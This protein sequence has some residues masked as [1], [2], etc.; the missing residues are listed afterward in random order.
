MLEFKKVPVIIWVS[1]YS[2]SLTFFSICN[3]QVCTTS[4]FVGYFLKD[5]GWEKGHLATDLLPLSSDVITCWEIRPGSRS[6]L[7]QSCWMGW[8]SCLR[9]VKVFNTKVRKPFFTVALLKQERAFPDKTIKN[10]LIVHLLMA[11]KSKS[12]VRNQTESVWSQW[13]RQ[14]MLFLNIIFNIFLKKDVLLHNLNRMN[15]LTSMPHQH[16]N[17]LFSVN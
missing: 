1:V 8:R 11:L 4:P 15:L 10:N 12:W 9:Q 2:Q 17:R 6:S 13:Q 5:T 3:S 7:S 14:N 16:S